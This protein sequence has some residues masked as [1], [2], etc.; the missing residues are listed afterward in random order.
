LWGTD[1]TRA[2]AVVHYE[3]AVKLF[4]ETDRLSDSERAMLMGGA[5]VKAYGWSPMKA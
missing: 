4:L 5:T 1:W 2:F 3:Q